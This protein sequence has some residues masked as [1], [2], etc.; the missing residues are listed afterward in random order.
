VFGKYSSAKSGY[1]ERR[2]NKRI[3]NEALQ[4][5]GADKPLSQTKKETSYNDR[6]I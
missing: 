2:D 4:Y 1:K 5:R 3:P 6:R